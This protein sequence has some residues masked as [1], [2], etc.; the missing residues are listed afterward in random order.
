MNRENIISK[1]PYIVIFLSSVYTLGGLLFWSEKI[2]ASFVGAIGLWTTLLFALSD[3]RQILKPV[4][5]V[6]LLMNSVEVFI[7]L[8]CGMSVVLCVLNFSEQL[9]E[10]EHWIMVVFTIISLL[11]TAVDAFLNFCPQ[12]KKNTGVIGGE[13]N[14]DQRKPR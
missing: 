1:M 11:V 6:R 13:T 2:T 10:I 12:Y 7:V 3:S 9:L 8:S 5:T 14:F 4:K